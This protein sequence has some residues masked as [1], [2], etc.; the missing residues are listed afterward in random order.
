MDYDFSITTL[1]HVITFNFCHWS[2]HI[3]RCLDVIGFTSIHVCWCGLGWNLV[4]V[5]LQSTSIHVDW[6]ESDYIQTRSYASMCIGYVLDISRV[7]WWV[8]WSTYS[9]VPSL[10]SS[11]STQLIFMK[12]CNSK[13]LIITSLCPIA[14]PC[15]DRKPNRWFISLLTNQLMVYYLI[16]YA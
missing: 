1:S 6:C 2:F 11:H 8:M 12:R 13:E 9:D 16:V 7:V 14:K 15:F 4:Q 5:P 3:R 10:L